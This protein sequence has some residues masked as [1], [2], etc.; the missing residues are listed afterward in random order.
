MMQPNDHALQLANFDIDLAVNYLFRC[1]PC[2]I[3]G[4]SCL[5][6]ATD[7]QLAQ[8][9]LTGRKPVG[10]FAF[11]RASAARRHARDMETLGLTTWTAK[12]KWNM[13]VVLAAL[14]PDEVIGDLGSARQR[15]FNLQFINEEVPF[16]I[17]GAMY[18][19]PPPTS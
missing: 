14:R 11:R 5:A 9:L 15:A 16:E 2:D 19:Y 7:D 12:N 3:C 10:S 8:R 13:W 18:G 6:D 4:G 1:G 17:M